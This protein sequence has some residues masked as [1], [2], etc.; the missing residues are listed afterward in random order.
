MVD[1][2]WKTCSMGEA[3]YMLCRRSTHSGRVFEVRTPLLRGAVLAQPGPNVQCK[4]SWAARALQ[5][6]YLFQ[7]K[8]RALPHQGLHGGFHLLPSYPGNQDFQGE[9]QEGEKLVQAGLKALP[10]QNGSPF[11][12]VPARAMIGSSLLTLKPCIIT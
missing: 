12:S 4:G 3:D 11:L 1:N 6:R 8:G 10:N 2:R 5:T 7:E 9:W